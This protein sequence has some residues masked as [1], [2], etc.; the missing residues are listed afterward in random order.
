MRRKD[1]TDALENLPFTPPGTE[2]I[3]GFGPD[4]LD[5]FLSAA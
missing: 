2:M 5:R 4:R 3:E 1:Q